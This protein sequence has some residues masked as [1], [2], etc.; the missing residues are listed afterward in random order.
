MFTLDTIVPW[1]RSF[2]E[3][4][5]MFRLTDSDLAK[6]ILSCGDGPAGFNAVM[7]QNGR[8]VVS[9]DPIYVFSAVEIE[10]QIEKTF[11][12]VMDQLRKNKDDYVW[13]QF[14]CPEE[15]G[16][17][18]MQAMKL[19]LSDFEHG[20]TEGRYVS[21]SLPEL[22]FAD[23]AFDIAVCS[24]L[25]FLYSAQLSLDFHV[26]SIREIL[27]VARDVRIFPVLELGGKTSRHLNAVI[28]SLKEEG[29][30]IELKSVD[31]EFQKNGNQ[32]MSVKR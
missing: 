28:A 23:D 32:M 4:V 25:L 2:D 1:G 30:N 7:R 20:K 22:S 18:R 26:R 8:T 6:R 21:D 31:Y 11:P 12:T 19:F 14:H 15:V 9:C 13:D 16:H 5:R 17:A 27:R 3:Y 10:S 29:Y 24:H